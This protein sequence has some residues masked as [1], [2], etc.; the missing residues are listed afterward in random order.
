MLAGR[1][2]T[3]DLLITIQL[4]YHLSYASIRLVS[5]E[6]QSIIRNGRSTAT[7]SNYLIL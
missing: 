3:S 7:A 1:I 2:R 6:E 5:D 4:L